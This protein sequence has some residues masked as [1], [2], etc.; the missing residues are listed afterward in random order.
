[1]TITPLNDKRKVDGA[2]R[3]IIPK[4]MRDEWHIEKDTVL[5]FFKLEMEGKSFLCLSQESTVNPE[6]YVAAKVLKDLGEN[7]PESLLNLIRD[8][9]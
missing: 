8:D 9:R 7:I 5:D 6:L 3:V 4:L 2:G 1:M